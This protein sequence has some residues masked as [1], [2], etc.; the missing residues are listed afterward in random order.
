MKNRIMIFLLSLVAWSYVGAQHNET[1]SQSQ[2]IKMSKKILFILM[3]ERYRDEE[4]TTPY[5][6]IKGANYHIDVAGFKAGEAIGTHG[7]VFTPNLLLENLKDT[8]FDTYD[9]LII[10]GGPASTTYLW[11]NETIQKIIQYFHG[12]SKIVATI[13]YACIAPVQSGILKGKNAT[14]F[15]TEEAKVHFTENDVTFSADGCVTLKDDKIITAQGPGFAKEF[16]KAILDLL[17]SE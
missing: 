10:P 17:G 15:P 12:N 8:D 1:I 9:A 4:F 11:N 13:C 2:E 14:V 5:E 16:G 6:M 3:P 7:N